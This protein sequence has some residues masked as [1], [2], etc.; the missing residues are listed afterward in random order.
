MWAAFL[1]EWMRR[2]G[3]TE[4]A[5]ARRGQKRGQPQAARPGR[6]QKAARYFE[7]EE[8]DSGSEEGGSEDEEEI[9]QQEEAQRAALTAMPPPVPAF[10]WQP[11]AP[12][13]KPLVGRTVAMDFGQEGIFF[14]LVTSWADGAYQILYPTDGQAEDVPAPK[15]QKLLQT[16]AD[17][18]VDLSKADPAAHG[19]GKIEAVLDRR[20]PV[21]AAAIDSRGEW[22]YLVQWC[23]S[24]HWHDAWVTEPML[25]ALARAKMQHFNRRHP[26]EGAPHTP[27]EG[28]VGDGAV[29]LS[30]RTVQRLVA[31]RNEQLGDLARGE[32]KGQHTEY[33]VKWDGLDYSHCTWERFS[34]QLGAKNLMGYEARKAAGDAPAARANQKKRKKKTEKGDDKQA[35][36]VALQEQPAGMSGGLLYPF[37]LEALNWI[38]FSRSEGNNVI[39]ADEMGLGKTVVS[40]ATICDLHDTLGE[41]CRPVLVVAPLSTLGNWEREAAFWVPHL[42]T[43]AYFG[44]QEARRIIRKY[45]LGS[46]PKNTPP[47]FD[48]LLTSY[49]LVT[50][51]SADIMKFDWECLIVD[52]GHNRLKTQTSALF[53][54]LSPAKTDHR[55]LLTG[56]PL[57]N[58]LS[59]LK[60]LLQFIQ[61]RE[62]VD[63]LD[64][65]EGDLSADRVESIRSILAPHILR[66][67]LQDVHLDMPAKKEVVVWCGLSPL[68]KSYLQ[69]VLTRNFALLNHGLSG[70]SKRRLMNVA[71]ECRKACN[72]PYLFPNAEPD[73]GPGDD[74]AHR[75]QVHQSLITSSGKFMLLDKMLPE[76]RSSGHRVLIFSQMTRVLDLLQD[77]LE[78]SGMPSVRL[79]GT[80]SATERQVLIERF[81]KP[82]S[83]LF[84]F[85]L[86][87]RAGGQGINLATADTVIIFDSDFNPHM[88]LQALARA[89]RI[90]QRRDVMVYRLVTRGTIEERVM[91]LSRKKLRLEKMIVQN[92]N[93]EESIDAT[94]DGIASDPAALN[95]LLQ[96]GTKQLFKDAD[97]TAGQSQPIAV[98]GE[99]A[100]NGLDGALLYDKDGLRQLLDRS[101]ISSSSASAEDGT[102]GNDCE[103][104]TTALMDSLKDARA[105]ERKEQPAENSDEDHADDDE[106][107][108]ENSQ[109]FWK[110]LLEE[111]Y[112]AQQTDSSQELGRGKRER[113]PVVAPIADDDY[114]SGE[115]SVEDANR[116]PVDAASSPESISSKR[117]KPNDQQPLLKK[118]PKNNH[119][120]HAATDN[121]KSVGRAEQ[122]FIDSRASAKTVGGAV[123]LP[124]VAA[125]SRPSS[126]PTGWDVNWDHKR[127]QW[128]YWCIDTRKVQWDPPTAIDCAE[129]KAA[130]QS[131]RA[132]DEGGTDSRQLQAETA[133]AVAAAAAAVAA[134]SAMSDQLSGSSLGQAPMPADTAGPCMVAAMEAADSAEAV[135]EDA[136][137]SAPHDL[138][139]AYR[140]AVVDMPEEDPAQ[141]CFRF[142]FPGPLGLVWC[143]AG[144]NI[145]NLV[146]KVESVKPE[147]P[148]AEKHIE[149]GL[150]LERVVYSTQGGQH[151][152]LKAGGAV[153]LA[154]LINTMN[155]F[156]PIC[157]CFGKMGPPPLLPSRTLTAID[158]SGAQAESRASLEPDPGTPPLAPAGWSVLWHQ[159]Y[160]RW[161]YRH[162]EADITTWHAPNH[163]DDV[164]DAQGT[165]SVPLPPVGWGLAWSDAHQRW[166]WWHLCTEQV[167]LLG[168]R[169]PQAPG[170]AIVASAEQQIDT[171]ARAN[172]VAA[173]AVATAAA[174][175]AGAG[176]PTAA[177]VHARAQL[178]RNRAHAA[179]QA[180]MAVLRTT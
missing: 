32:P 118:E 85:L 167:V 103:S 175:A 1:R 12:P 147:S 157:L 162:A 140:R 136:E 116:E 135:L 89:Y 168:D 130:C 31:K 33:L 112:L 174:A 176:G 144:P 146:L 76:L 53:S 155:K 52:E 65:E 70:S 82:D 127:R 96:H 94:R 105:W 51:D 62:D 44:N 123:T 18:Q 172:A 110:K 154:A 5:P 141:L 115:E 161:Y 87:T 106:T 56:T 7:E 67:K 113:K 86:S 14:G 17:F 165:E 108:Q 119:T 142:H 40:M 145:E 47:H 134:P 15:L 92:K 139:C 133:P 28:A 57:Q 26:K 148:A 156:R 20:R 29:P 90:G 128:Y 107:D 42:N 93:D 60:S 117:K 177:Q 68:Q 95:H 38:R 125:P 50:K 6:Q 22:E 39:L 48:I 91:Q 169:E 171:V 98:H 54:A 49:E 88:D 16:R 78:G 46:V 23:G 34:L 109:N 9:L 3:G 129:S 36:F 84:C 153:P 66:R 4:E 24:G 11:D 99:M 120:A 180:A 138:C 58:N 114:V 102:A 100:N 166:F 64:I 101:A 59:E 150:W 45:E 75:K 152:E 81:N 179:L 80:T 71:M 74:D 55:I 131:D 173:A 61:V 79:D 83:P 21:A 35:E 143:S 25:S 178:A 158:A 27:G 13:E 19:L 121:T 30:W 77:Y 72:H 69:W 122:D 10:A 97:H 164:V 41:S 111:R 63:A 126:I 159:V 137:V 104:A 132:G 163:G 124:A 160:E 8:S 37:Q 2:R 151:F 43:V 149:P 170:A 73:F